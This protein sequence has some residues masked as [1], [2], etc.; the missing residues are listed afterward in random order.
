VLRTVTVACTVGE[1]QSGV[2]PLQQRRNRRMKKALHETLRTDVQEPTTASVVARLAILAS[3]LAFWVLLARSTH[4]EIQHVVT[5]TLA[6]MGVAATLSLLETAKRYFNPAGARPKLRKGELMSLLVVL[7]D[8]SGGSLTLAGAARAVQQQHGPID[9]TLVVD[10]L[11]GLSAH[12]HCTSEYND[13][14]TVERW[15]FSRPHVS[16]SPTTLPSIP[17]RHVDA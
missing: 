6:L 14:G 3:T 17:T 4:E 15:Q 8:E 16:N 9:L 1:W 7:A 13:D 11:A 2:Y 12:G 10:A 5:S